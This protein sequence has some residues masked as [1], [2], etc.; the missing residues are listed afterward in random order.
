MV[1]IDLER[2]DVMFLR[3]V[4]KDYLAKE[5]A[6]A[7]EEK[8]IGLEDKEVARG[9]EEMVKNLI[10]RLEMDIEKEAPLRFSA[11]VDIEYKN[12][13]MGKGDIAA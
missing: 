8:P 9:R 5:H 4:L 10:E 12:T 7:E 13:D 11:P 2:D 3:E 1:T 6:V